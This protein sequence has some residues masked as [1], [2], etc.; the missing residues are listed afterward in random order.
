MSQWGSDMNLTR[1]QLAKFLPDPRTIKQFEN[2]INLVSGLEPDTLDMLALV[3]GGA[4]SKAN[5]ALAQLTRIADSLEALSTSPAQKNDT[6]LFGDYLDFPVN[7]PHVSQERR[8]QWNAD[9]GTLDV[10]MFG[11]EVL[12]V[13][14][15]VLYY[16]KNTS[17]G[18][19]SKGTPV[20]YN[21]TVGSSGKLT[22]TKAVAN[23]SSPSDYML[24]VACHDVANNEFGYVS[25]FGL[26]RGFDT[27]GTPYGEVW[28]DGTVLYFGTGS[29]G[30][31]TSTQPSPPAI[32][33][34]AA[35]VVKAASGGS[36]SIMVRLRANESV[37]DLRDVSA[38]APSDGSVLIFDNTTNI[39]NARQ[40][41]SS[42]NLNISKSGTTLNFDT[43]GATGSFVAGAKTVTVSK[44]I[45][46]SIV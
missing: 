1:E 25:A 18:S 3:A 39:W 21:G 46:T 19:I 16:A 29:A 28:G 38:V 24:G 12:Q 4:D 45:I 40:L 41:T 33:S 30:S 14:Q 11:G 27:S 36:G 5:E 44:G 6:F 8:L 34:P 17:G 13:G 15:E 42:S 7:G 26:V 22:F 23:G 43:A 10:G 35:V 31:W 9:D 2:L 20:M 37:G 32:K